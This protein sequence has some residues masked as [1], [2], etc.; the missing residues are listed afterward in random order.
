MLNVLSDGDDS[1]TDNNIVSI[2]N[3]DDGDDDTFLN[4]AEKKKSVSSTSFVYD[5]VETKTSIFAFNERLAL[6][7]DDTITS[8]V[9]HPTCGRLVTTSLDGTMKITNLSNNKSIMMN[10][11]S[12]SSEDVIAESA[13]MEES[14]VI[15]VRSPDGAGFLCAAFLAPQ[16]SKDLL[17]SAMDGDSSLQFWQVSM[18][19]GGSGT[20]KCI[21]VSDPLPNIVT[22]LVVEQ[23]LV[24]VAGGDDAYAV[25]PITGTT[26]RE[27]VAHQDAIRCITFS[28]GMLFTGSQDA[29]I[30]SWDPLGASVIRVLSGH[31]AAVTCLSG[32]DDLMV[33]GS[34][35]RTIRIWSS[36]LGSCLRVLQSHDDEV[37][38]LLVSPWDSRPFV[39]SAS[40][41]ST[42]R[43]WSLHTLRS[44]VVAR[45]MP[46]VVAVHDTRVLV[47]TYMGG[48]EVW[49]L[50]K[51]EQ[52]LVDGGGDANVDPSAP[53]AAVVG[54]SPS[55]KTM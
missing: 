36:T 24:F 30:R 7:H 37:V 16:Q 35:D 47:A 46:S 18:N 50:D 2:L 13:A 54:T 26:I 41:D 32:K 53:I 1:A 20:A 34:E 39:Y 12:G 44:A 8:M 51:H 22:C 49:D 27:F 17:V 9:M 38:S 52:K 23:D 4:F 29:T 43:C 5:P 10:K 40:M 6:H 45:V 3:K 21:G 55:K 28:E 19:R 15:T 31:K 42:V 48:V 14:D 25:S 33:S 11:R